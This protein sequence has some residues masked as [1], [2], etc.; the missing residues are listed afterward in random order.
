MVLVRKCVSSIPY[1]PVPRG[2]C[3]SQCYNI[4]TRVPCSVDAYQESGLE[5]VGGHSDNR[6]S[7]GGSYTPC[8]NS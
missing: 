8:I 4:Y 7:G 2:M 6:Q 3:G 5:V 1:H